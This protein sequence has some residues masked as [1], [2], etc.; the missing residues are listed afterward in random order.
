MKANFNL[1][2]QF[3]WQTDVYKWYTN[4]DWVVDLRL[5]AVQ[6]KDVSGE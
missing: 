5:G 2:S 6:G 4:R 1:D 3:T